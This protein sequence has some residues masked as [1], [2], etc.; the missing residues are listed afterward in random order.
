MITYI[1]PLNNGYTD[2]SNMLM[3]RSWTV[4]V[5]IMGF[6]V[7]PDCQFGERVLRVGYNM[8]NM[9]LFFNDLNRA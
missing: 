5:A 4:N 9:I 7:I 3:A 1:G 6:R 8:Y 2:N